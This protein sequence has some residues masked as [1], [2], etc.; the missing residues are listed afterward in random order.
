MV[1]TCIVIAVAIL[2]FVVWCIKRKKGGKDV[3]QGLQVFDEAGNTVIGLSTRL[4]RRRGVIYLNTKSGS[5]GLNV[6]DANRVWMGVAVSDKHSGSIFLGNYLMVN[7]NGKTISWNY[8]NYPGLRADEQGK[9]YYYM[10][11]YGDY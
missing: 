10:L 9:A 4:V 2:G 11:V 5:A 8:D 3:P 7:R 6:D 1:I